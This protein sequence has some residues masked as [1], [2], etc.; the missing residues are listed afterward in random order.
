MDVLDQY[1]PPDM[2]SESGSLG[3][4][5]GKLAVFIGSTPNIGTTLTALGTAVG[6]SERSDDPVGFLCLNLKSSKLHRYL[7]LEKCP[8]GLDQIRAEMRSASLTPAVLASCFSPLKAASR[9]HVMY[10]TVQREQAEF[11]QPEDIRHLLE[12]VRTTYSLCVVDVNA[13][14]D[15]A[16]TITGL[17]EADSRVLVTTPDL[18]HFQ[19]DVARGVKAVAPLFNLDTGSFLL[20]VNQHTARGTGG[21]KASDIAKETGM[22]L[23]SVIPWDPALRES[24]NQG[25]LAEYVSRNKAFVQ[26]LEPLCGQLARRFSL[27]GGRQKQ[28]SPVRSW[29]P[30]FSSR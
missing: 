1:N 5:A 2:A 20:A 26:A 29:L 13:Y 21:I 4:G 10:G 8:H 25:G 14:W 15:N 17:M 7:G 16:A 27:K 30:L 3:G 24:M 9:V 22:P 11:Y 19:E 12:T 23:T 18:G 28:A 6:L